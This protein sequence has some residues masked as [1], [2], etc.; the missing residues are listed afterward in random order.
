MQ[1]LAPSDS[2]T[3]SS[4]RSWRSTACERSDVRLSHAV[5]EFMPLDITLESSGLR[6][7]HSRDK[8]R[9]RMTSAT[10]VLIHGASDSG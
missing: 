10:Y 8:D 5:G 9:L 6:T 1:P 3:P 7:A 4:N 2:H